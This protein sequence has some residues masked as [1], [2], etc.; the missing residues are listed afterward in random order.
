MIEKVVNRPERLVYRRE[1]H[2]PAAV[3]VNRA[4]DVH[5]YFEGVTVKPEAFVP[6]LHM[7]EP[8]GRLER[9]FLEDLHQAIPRNLW[10]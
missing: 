8:M 3:G 7:R 9:E 10:V 6:G 5:L 1:V 4:V 2:D